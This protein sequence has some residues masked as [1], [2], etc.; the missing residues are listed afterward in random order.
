MV[1]SGP[2]PSGVED[3]GLTWRW[4]RR[5]TA[6]ALVQRGRPWVWPA[7]QLG[8]SA[9]YYNRDTMRLES[10]TENDIRG[11][12]EELERAK[13]RPQSGDFLEGF[14][15][16]TVKWSR[17]VLEYAEF[18]NLFLFWD[19]SAWGIPSPL[20]RT[21]RDGV[22]AFAQIASQQPNNIH[23]GQIQ[24]WLQKCKTGELRHNEPL[25]I[26]GGQDEHSRLL[27]L[28][29]NHRAAAV[30]WWF[31]QSGGHSQ[32]PLNAWVGLSPDMVRYRYYQRLF[33]L[34]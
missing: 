9:T 29:G 6:Q 32:L 25:F 14:P 13:Q 23:L 16:E 17:A 12:T 4:R 26:L 15:W 11:I 2:D 5:A 31:M 8:R 19:G 7:P 24:A 3:P 28:D 33:W 10:A 34:Q 20:P 18:E 27:I 22:I 30:L 1:L 21:L